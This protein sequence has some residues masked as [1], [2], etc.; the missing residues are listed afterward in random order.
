MG[1]CW[2]VDVVVFKSDFKHECLMFL[3]VKLT[4]NRERCFIPINAH[5][6][7]P[8]GA[9][10]NATKLVLINPTTRTQL[11]YSSFQSVCN[12][13]YQ[14]GLLGKVSDPP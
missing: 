10:L 13:F 8:S 9:S 6:T 5:K 4:R 1:L 2:F 3:K 12:T 11:R 7:Y 14:V